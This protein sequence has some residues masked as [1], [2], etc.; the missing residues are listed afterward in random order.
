MFSVL[1]WSLNALLMT[2]VGGAGTF[3]GPIVGV[4]IV[5]YGLIKGLEDLQ[6]L[7]LILEG[8]LLVVIVRF[9]PFGVWPLALR[10]SR[11]L[12]ARSRGRRPIQKRPSGDVGRGSLDTEIV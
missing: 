9:A 2:I 10:L 7:S 8:V 3:F 6:T 11:L 1:S 12:A 4:L 5:Y